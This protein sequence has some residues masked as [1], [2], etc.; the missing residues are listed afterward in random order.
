MEITGKIIA[1]LPSRS[2]VSKEGKSWMTQEFVLETHD[3]YPRK[4]CFDVFG[5]ERLKQFNIQIGGEYT[6]SFDIDAR[7][8]TDKNGQERWTNSI[9]AWRCIDPA[10]AQQAPA[11][12][13][14]AANVQQAAAPAQQADAPQDDLGN[15]PF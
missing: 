4:V 1:A 2:G 11:A 15:M 12:Q 14:A 6:I 10:A 5:E 13:Q 8:W 7:S 9:R 3:Q